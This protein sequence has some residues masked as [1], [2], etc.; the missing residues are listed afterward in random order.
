[1]SELKRTLPELGEAYDKKM[2]G[3]ERHLSI[4][5]RRA[6][7]EAAWETMETDAGRLKAIDH[8]E[9]TA[10]AKLAGRIWDSIKPQK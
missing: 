3:P 10:R 5:F 8:D 6:F 1:M 4:Y 2:K 7:I 9:T